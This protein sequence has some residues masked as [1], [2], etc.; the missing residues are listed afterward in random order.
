MGC[1]HGHPGPCP[2]PWRRVVTDPSKH[3]YLP[4]LGDCATQ[5]Q[6]QWN[7][8]G[9][10]GGEGRGPETSKQPEGQ[11]VPAGQGSAERPRKYS[12]VR[13]ESKGTRSVVR[14]KGE[15]GGGQ[16][17]NLGP[18]LRPWHGVV[19]DPSKHCYLPRLGDC[20]TQQR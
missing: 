19:T 9:G 2:G 7:R 15:G 3:C 18:C 5:R 11:P 10:G 16:K 20:K 1:N 4:C 17:K 12:P 14:G 6:C 13:R 8:E